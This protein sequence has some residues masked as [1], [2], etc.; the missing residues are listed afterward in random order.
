MIIR[1]KYLKK[2]KDFS[3]IKEISSYINIMLKELVNEKD[4]IVVELN[5]KKLSDNFNI[6]YNT[7]KEKYDKYKK[8]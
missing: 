4:D 3:N 5:L 6:D 7:I 2:D 1:W 8:K